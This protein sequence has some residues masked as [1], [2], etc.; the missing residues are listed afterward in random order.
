MTDNFANDLKEINH[1]SKEKRSKETKRI[2][3]TNNIEQLRN[4]LR[5][6]IDR[7]TSL[8]PNPRQRNEAV[9]GCLKLA[10]NL[11]TRV[12]PKADALKN[13]IQE[14]NEIADK[15]EEKQEK[16]KQEAKEQAEQE[17]KEYEKSLNNVKNLSIGSIKNLAKKALFTTITLTPPKIIFVHCG[18]NTMLKQ[19]IGA[20]TLIS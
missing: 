12:T 4:D 13:S 10:Q 5:K 1:N 16:Y 2:N 8:F 6:L 17:A 18:L 20:L 11:L 15:E 9:K 14:L 3:K 19:V 7:V